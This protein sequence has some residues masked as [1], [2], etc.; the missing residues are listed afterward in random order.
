[1]KRDMNALYT[2]VTHTIKLGLS[3][4]LLLGGACGCSDLLDKSPNSSIADG[5][6][7]NNEKDAYMALVGCYVF[8]VDGRMMIL[9]HRV[10]KYTW[11]AVVETVWR[12]RTS[13]A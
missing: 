2:R 7:W 11:T 5:N 3:F 9:L 12:R 10:D 4:L 13:P 1:M 6:F 8:Q